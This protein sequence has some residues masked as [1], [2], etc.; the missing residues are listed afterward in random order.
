MDRSSLLV[1][2]NILIFIIFN[3]KICKLLSVVTITQFQYKKDNSEFQERTLVYRVT[4]SVLTED[5]L[6]DTIIDTDVRFADFY[7]KHHNTF[8]Q[9]IDLYVGTF[10]GSNVKFVF[11]FFQSFD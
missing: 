6:S 5:S 9:L 10:R 1:K 7:S 3:T 11:N 8:A 4:W 2:P